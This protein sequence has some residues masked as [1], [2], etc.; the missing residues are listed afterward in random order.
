MA[1]IRDKPSPD[2]AIRYSNLYSRLQ[3]QVS[4]SL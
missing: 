1:V 4:L 2:A 3:A